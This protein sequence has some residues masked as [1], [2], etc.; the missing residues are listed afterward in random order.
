[1]GF[2][3]GSDG[4]ESA[5]NAG[6]LG[7]ISGLGWSPGEGYGNPLQCSC[8]KNSMDREAWGAA[9]QEGR[10]VRQGR[11]TLSHTHTHKWASLVAQTVKCLPTM[12]ETQVPSLGWEDLL[13]KEMATHSSI[14]AWKIPWTEGPGRLQSMG[15]QR[16]GHNWATSLYFT[17][18]VHLY[19]SVCV[20][21][22]ICTSV[23]PVIYI[24]LLYTFCT[25]LNLT[26][27]TE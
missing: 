15:S 11:V 25:N 9:V 4:K 12:R 17:L 16:V 1:M 14:L 13:E 18:Y 19:T 26:Y 20:Y 8:L 6:V 23:F 5:H 27:D 10:R 7:S 3:G 22:Y 2:P 24:H 21:T